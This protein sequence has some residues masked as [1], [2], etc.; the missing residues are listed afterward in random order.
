[1]TADDPWREL[2]PPSSA[3]ALSARLVDAGAPW[4]F[5]WARDLDRSPLLLLRHAAG[6]SP[7]G[8][9]PRLKG[10]EITL[11]EPEANGQRVLA[12]RLLDAAQRDVFHRLCLD[13][14]ASALSAR[15]EPEAV[16]RTVARTWRWHHLLRGGT[17]EGLSLEE[18]KGLIGELQVLEELLLPCLGA[19]DA[20]TSWRGPLGA[21][22]DFEVGRLAIEAK[23]RR[24]AA[25]PF[26]AISSEYQLSTD[27]TD[28]LFLHVAELSQAPTGTAGAFILSDFARRLH[29]SVF[30]AD[31]LAAEL[32]E[33]RLL[34]GGFD[35]ADDYSD[36]LFVAGPARVYR[37]VE[38]FPSITP[39]ILRPG[40]AQV[41]Y[42]IS[43]PACEAF[44][45]SHEAVRAAIMGVRNGD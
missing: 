9:L 45:T 24:G 28:S 8:Q 40:I 29:E 41:R 6:A 33:G 21:P 23:A 3:D 18:Q 22:K 4:P 15:T 36:A 13:I 30:K 35:W 37:V 16:S 12:L 32:F 10:L 43:L 7:T 5:Y 14:I 19:V 2:T 17:G 11:S 39:T 42:A 20:V 44:L 25:R 38:S 31:H 1:M 27:G 26:V 34:A